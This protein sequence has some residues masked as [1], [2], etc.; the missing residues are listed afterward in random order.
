MEPFCDNPKCHFNQAD[1]DKSCK[2]IDLDIPVEGSSVI[3]DVMGSTRVKTIHRHVLRQKHGKLMGKFCDS[4]Q[5]AM[6]MYAPLIAVH[7]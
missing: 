6:Q 2:E 7:S 5:N 1:V 3:I 4:C